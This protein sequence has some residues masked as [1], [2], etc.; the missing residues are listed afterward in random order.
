MS[1]IIPGISG[2]R[3][4][5]NASFFP[6][7]SLDFGISFGSLIPRSRGIIVGRDTRKTSPLMEQAFVSGL[8]STGSQV[9]SLGIVPTPTV[10]L[11]TALLKRDGG[12]VITASH[13]PP[14]WNGIKFNNK[15]GVFLSE[16]EIKKLY[17]IYNKK[18]FNFASWDKTGA[19]EYDGQ[20]IKRHLN[21]VLA[22]INVEM[23][24]KKK[25][26]VVFD[27]GFGTLSSP[28]KTLLSHL[29]C[30]TKI[31]NAD[32]NPEPIPSNLKEIK[33]ICRSGDFDVGF[34]SDMD[35][36][37]IAII[38]E[39]G[40]A[41]GEEYTLALALSHIFN[42]KKGKV[43]TNLSTSRM[44][45]YIAGN[46]LIRT[47]VGEANVVGKMLKTGAIFGGEGNGG[48]IWPDMH[49]TRDGLSAI[50]IILEYMAEEGESISNLM[51]RL[52]SYFMKKEKLG[53]KGALHIERVLEFLPEGKI[54]RDDGIR[55]DYEDAFIHIRKS[56]TE[57]VI[58]IICEAESEKICNM[59]IKKTKDA[60]I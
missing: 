16:G 28:A 53:I 57:N 59:F 38:T 24:R 13:N 34:A 15:E 25:L 11:N 52:P 40:E 43:V 17:R 33:N 44:I 27:G 29:G 60:L 50:S 37:R 20:G 39:K 19:L 51:K 10:L 26:R 4:I 18:K 8:L 42:Q 58:R 23:I 55:I 7:D 12:A 56:N 2:V 49:T 36:D 30:K 54:N 3:G 35:G 47:K 46:Y 45:D 21:R 41:P 5:V 31:I 1:D 14:C 48:V 32:R 9:L 22:L 6:Q